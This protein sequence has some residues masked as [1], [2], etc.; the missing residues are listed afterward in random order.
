MI[1]PVDSKP[2]GMIKINRAP[3]LTLWV[4]VVASRRG[5]SWETALSFGK[6]IASKFA[7]A[8]GHS[9]GIVDTD[10]SSPRKMGALRVDKSKFV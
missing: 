7:Q 4:A 2:V 6:S 5:F 8:K 10:E 3:V 1:S 9:L